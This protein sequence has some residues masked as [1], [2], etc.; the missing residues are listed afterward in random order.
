MTAPAPRKLPPLSPLSRLFSGEI[1]PGIYLLDMGERAQTLCAQIER[2]GWRCFLLDGS[3]V[4]DKRSFLEAIAHAMHFPSYAGRNWDA[5]EELITDLSWAEAPGYI[6]IYDHA[7]PL[8]AQHPQAWNTVYSILADAVA[9]WAKRSRP[10]Y[11]LLRNPGQV[12]QRPPYARPGRGHVTH[13]AP[14]PPATESDI[15]P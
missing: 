10:F 7:A 15:T 1:P 5:F 6:L 8:V 11:V 12:P 14:Q 13:A 2:H 4:Y 9:D 3:A